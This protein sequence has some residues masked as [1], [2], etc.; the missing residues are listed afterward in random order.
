[1]L[2]P[3]QL[4]LASHLSAVTLLFSAFLIPPSRLSHTKLA[5]AFLPPIWACHTYSWSVGLG[6]LAAVQVLWATELLLFQNPREKFHV[7]HHSPPPPSS[8]TE[9][10]KDEAGSRSNEESE[11]DDKKMQ[12]W[13]EPYPLD[14]ILKR[15]SWVFKLLISL[16]YVGWDIGSP[17]S[18]PST[19]VSSLPR[20]KESRIHWLLKNIFL[21]GLSFLAIDATNAY[22]HMDP[23]FQVETSIDSPFP[24]RLA[25]SLA[26]WGLAFLSPRMVRIVI[27]G[28]QQYAVFTMINRVFAIV[29]VLLGG[30]GILDGWWGGVEN[31]PMLM[32]SPAVVWRSGLK[33]FWGRGWH[34]LFRYVSSF[35]LLNV[36]VADKARYSRA[37]EIPL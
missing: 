9:G 13:K 2:T 15:A 5:L 23:Y 30:L 1:M 21:A 26:S 19:P 31:W 12:S 22:Q 28:V 8:K 14:S 37:L 20:R 33:G 3:I 7:I 24:Q 32:G 29:H 11:K 25:S 34:Q 36:A 27:S 4:G 17:T 16:R 10:G 35:S 18:I 6:F